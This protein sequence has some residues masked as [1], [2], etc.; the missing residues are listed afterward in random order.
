MK[1]LISLAVLLAVS[2]ASEDGDAPSQD[3]TSSQIKNLLSKAT[4][5]NSQGRQV[6]LDS[7]RGKYIGLYFSGYWCSPCRKMTPVLTQVREKQKSRFE[8]IWITRDHSET[9]A[10]N[11][12]RKMSWLRLPFNEARSIGNELFRAVRQRY[13][14][15]LTMLDPN[16][17]VINY[18]ARSQIERDSSGRNFPWRS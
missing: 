2:L 15:T 17:N 9:E 4:L 16:F 13:I 7:L 14:P 11:Y 12:F 5:Y 8:I 3:L 18:N 10:N 1:L 6:S